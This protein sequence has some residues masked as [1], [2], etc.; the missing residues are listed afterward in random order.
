METQ[1]RINALESRQLELRALM[2]KS[3]AHASKCVK[4]GTKFSTQYPEEAAAYKAANTEYNENEATLEEL[5]AQRAQEE[6]QGD[7]F[8]ETAPQE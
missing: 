1:E 4:M 8:E 6:A 7:R 5:Y 3:D 2:A